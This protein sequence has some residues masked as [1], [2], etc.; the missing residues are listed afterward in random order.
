MINIEQCKIFIREYST[1]ISEIARTRSAMNQY[2]SE[3]N[4]SHVPY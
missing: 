1:R 4:A 3:T 2:I